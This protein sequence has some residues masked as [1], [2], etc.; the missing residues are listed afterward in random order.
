MTTTNE[1]QQAAEQLEIGLDVG[2]V[3]D[4]AVDPEL[5]AEECRLQFGDQL[6]GGFSLQPEP[7]S[8]L[9]IQPG[10]V[11][12]PMDELVKK[13]GAELRAPLKGSESGDYDLVGVTRIERLIDEPV[14]GDLRPDLADE[15]VN[16]KVA[17]VGIG[18]GRAGD[19]VRQSSHCE[20]LNTT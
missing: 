19:P 5:R 1:H 4:E 3:R 12:R 10:G 16:E 6:L 7:S 11:G 8:E 13:G 9:P 18:P 2:R 17:L 15:L 14:L 20:M